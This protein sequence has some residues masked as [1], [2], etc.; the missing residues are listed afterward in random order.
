MAH[1]D[2]SGPPSYRVNLRDA[3]SAGEPLD[4][5]VMSWVR[6]AW[7]ID[8]RDGYGHRDDSSDIGA[9]PAN[10]SDLDRWDGRSRRHRGTRRRCLYYLHRPLRRCFRVGGPSHQPLRGGACAPEASRG[11]R[12]RQWRRRRIQCVCSCLRP[13]RAGE[14]AT[15]RAGTGARHLGICAAVECAVQTDPAPR[16]C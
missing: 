4:P 15:T 12:R 13:Y 6:T 11:C 7:G 16:V 5:E 2:P 9:R 10:R 3:P 8:I 1:A 14:R